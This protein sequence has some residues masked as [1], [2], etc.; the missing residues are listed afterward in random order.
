[1]EKLKLDLSR[2]YTL[3][4]NSAIPLPCYYKG[5]LYTD[6][7]CFKKQK[8]KAVYLTVLAHAFYKYLKKQPAL[9]CFFLTAAADQPAFL[10]I[11][12]FIQYFSGVNLKTAWR[13]GT[14]CFKMI[15]EHTCSSCVSSSLYIKEIT[16]RNIT[17]FVLLKPNIFF[18]SP[19]NYNEIIDL[20]SEAFYKYNNLLELI[21]AFNAVETASVHNT[22]NLEENQEARKLTNTKRKKNILLAMTA[23]ASAL[24]SKEITAH[25]K[26][27]YQKGGLKVIS[28][29]DRNNSAFKADFFRDLS[30]ECLYYNI[31]PARSAGAG[32]P[33]NTKFRKTLAR[34][35]NSDVLYGVQYSADGEK[36]KV[37][38]N[39][40]GKLLPLTFE[41]LTA[42]SVMANISYLN[43]FFPE[44]LDRYC[45][46]AAAE[47]SLVADHLCSYINGKVFRCEDDLC[48][49]QKL[50]RQ[51]QK[52]NFFPGMIISKQLE[53]ISPA[54]FI[55]PDPLLPQLALI[56]LFYLCKKDKKISLLENFYNLMTG[57]FL[58]LSRC[59]PAVIAEIHRYKNKIIL[60]KSLPEKKM[61]I[62]F[63]QDLTGRIN[64][65]F[66]ELKNSTA[67]H[68][69]TYSYELYRA[70]VLQFGLNPL[71]S[72][73]PY[74]LR[75]V[76]KKK[77]VFAVYNF[78]LINYQNKIKVCRCA[79]YKTE[80]IN[81]LDHI[82]KS[83]I[84]QSLH[85][86][87]KASS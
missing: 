47:T 54:S 73:T 18:L 10:S 80:E 84:N 55:C 72:G 50:A 25:S 2:I 71:N 74:D 58:P 7:S 52:E 36:I 5:A 16:A 12:V 35:L 28:A 67:Y 61:Y 22:L 66:L 4:K 24:Y 51:K 30:V 29:F 48:S 82:V 81:K 34:K 15:Q 87:A 70:T 57:T 20:F 38:Y 39:N 69:F 44:H 17:R 68:N 59:L 65:D 31:P 40:A 60:E 43:L 46:I 33:V 64:K 45:I 42:V 83:N 26:R 27:L 56:E 75:L 19:D 14:P 32:I 41:H 9:D 6:N 77:K 3:Q 76:L 62:P 49:L 79:D 78:S 86:I 21:T 53:L 37:Y 8:D 85:A 63:L 13:P 11:K 23:P 1:M